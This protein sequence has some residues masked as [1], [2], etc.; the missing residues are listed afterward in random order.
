MD[1]WVRACRSPNW[2]AGGPLQQKKDEKAEEKQER[3]VHANV[4]VP[5]PWYRK[6][7]SPA[8]TC[9]APKDLLKKEKCCDWKSDSAHCV[10]VFG[11]YSKT[12]M[13]DWVTMC[14]AAH[15]ES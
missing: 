11:G 1:Q 2:K 4:V 10:A 14:R 5:K 13:N 12:A 3:C 6:A 15:W 7:S 9:L 8:A